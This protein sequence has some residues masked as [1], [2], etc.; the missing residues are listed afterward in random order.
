MTGGSTELKYP[1]HTA[2]TEM[3]VNYGR[4]DIV[5]SA[6]LPAPLMSPAALTIDNQVYLFGNIS[7]PERLSLKLLND[8]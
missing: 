7:K 3:S 5:F 8:L 2:V 1:Y 6:S 4:W